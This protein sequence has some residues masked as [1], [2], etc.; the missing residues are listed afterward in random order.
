MI[1]VQ[2]AP[3]DIAAEYQVIKGGRTDIGGIAMFVGTVRDLSDGQTISAMELEHY[4]GMTEL[5]L[6]RIEE[7]A[8]KRWP[9][10]AS[11]IVH[12]YGKLVPGDDIVL[13][14][15]ASEHRGDAFDACQFLMDWLKT[16]A[17]FWKLES[18]GD[19]S[20]WVDARKT[21]DKAASRWKR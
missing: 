18:H 11:L 17:P 7:E 1:K 15:T 8:Q 10:K 19:R 16:N 6:A 14:I 20:N 21:D 9:L 12:R 3:F 13:V 4:P 5:E 2:Q